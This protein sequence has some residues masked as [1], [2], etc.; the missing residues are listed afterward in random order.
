MGSNDKGRTHAIALLLLA[1]VVAATTILLTRYVSLG[2]TLAAVALPVAQMARDEAFAQ[3]FP[4][5]LLCI[6]TAVFVIWAHR[7]NI[8]RLRRGEEHRIGGAKRNKTE[9]ATGSE[10]TTTP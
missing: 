8:R 1:L 7:G 4:A 9:G 10:G 6:V 2:S 3:E 5:T